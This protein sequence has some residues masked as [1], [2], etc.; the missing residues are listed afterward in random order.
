MKEGCRVTYI[1]TFFKQDLFGSLYFFEIYHTSLTIDNSEN[2]V[3]R[4][5]FEKCLLWRA[6]ISFQN[7]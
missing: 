3:K 6:Q 5:C 4:G 1:E 7:E 2:V